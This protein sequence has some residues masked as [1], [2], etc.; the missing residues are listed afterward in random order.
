MIG[1]AGT[2]QLSLYFPYVGVNLRFGKDN[3]RTASQKIQEI[4]FF[5]GQMDG[6]APHPHSTAQRI[7][8]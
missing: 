1:H 4:K 6:F 7:D 2:A 3:A 5:R 8:Q